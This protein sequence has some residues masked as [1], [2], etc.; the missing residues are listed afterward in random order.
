MSIIRKVFL[1]KSYVLNTYYKI[2]S[3]CFNF[4]FNSLNNHDV[5][6]NDLLNA[7]DDLE[8]FE[9]SARIFDRRKNCKYFQ[10]QS[11]IILVLN[12]FQALRFLM[13]N[14][15]DN[16]TLR[17]YAGDIFVSLSERKV[18]DYIVHVG[19]IM[20]CMVKIFLLHHNKFGRKSFINIFDEYKESLKQ[21]KREFSLLST[22]ES[23]FRKSYYILIKLYN[24][25]NLM[26]Y[27]IFGLAH[28][29]TAVINY[30]S[31]KPFIIQLVHTAL[32]IAIYY[33]IISSALWFLFILALVALFSCN[34]IDS[35]IT[36]YD[37]LNSINHYAWTNKLSFY[38]KINL[39]NNWIDCFNAQSAWL[40]YFAYMYAAFHNIL[41]F[42]YL[43]QF[44]FDNLGVKTLLITSNILI[45][46]ILY[47]SNYLG[48]LIA[49]KGSLLYMSI[50]RA[51]VDTGKSNNLEV[52][53][54]KL[55]V[56][57]RFKARKIGAYIGNYIYIDNNNALIL[58]LECA[59]LYFLFCANIHRNTL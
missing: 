25:F 52:A 49:Q 28:I 54:K 34:S 40:M 12:S 51:S 32:I 30:S 38:Y 31:L 50:Y 13:L 43:T 37:K 17:L 19:I 41:I 10:L 24:Y 35:L 55:Q 15:T 14:I 3:F 20:P 58:T 57:E 47:V 59:S 16:E 56:L 44:T 46:L 33:F 4:S 26:V 18:L 22:N 53:L 29:S 8:R 1:L 23:S 11:L 45:L 7:I 42:F 6:R 36:E 48:S 27:I 9:R 2:R 21:Y 39:L 5:T